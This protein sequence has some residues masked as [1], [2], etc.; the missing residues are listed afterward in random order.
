M[1]EPR[2]LAVILNYQTAEMTLRSAEAALRALEG[3]NAELVIVDN[4]S[5]DGSFEMLSSGVAAKNMSDNMPVRVVQSGHNGGFGAG[6]NFG[7]NTGRSDGER[8][9]FVYIL[10]SDAFPAKQ[11]VRK[12]VTYLKQHPNIGFAGSYIHG[13]DGI[14]HETAF[15]FPSAL[16][17]LEGAMR[18]GPVSRLLRKHIVPLPV[19]D[20]TVMVDWLAG[21]SMMM[22]MDV[23]EEIGQF[24]E[25]FFLYFEETDLCR[26]AA[27]A[28]WPTVYVRESEVEH[29]GSVS[30]GM[31]EWARVPNYWFD[32]RWYYFA[33]NYSK[34]Y[35]LYATALHLL[36]GGFYRFRRFA[37]RKDPQMPPHFLRTLASHACKSVFKPQTR[38]TTAGPAGCPTQG[39]C[40]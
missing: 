8:A 5:G 19:P 23:L 20:E 38:N 3:L 35:A 37:E 12:L 40:K 31:K 14:A 7:I 1:T 33:K 10:N 30:T 18:F 22:R 24:D 36:G 9:D 28:G 13:S 26:R 21:A 2:L 11:A 29:I 15:R 4:D 34:I 39:E 6:N 27:I 25:T 16:S 17:E 32:S